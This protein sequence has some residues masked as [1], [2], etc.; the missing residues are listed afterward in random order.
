MPAHPHSHPRS[1]CQAHPR[2]Q[3]LGGW[4][5]GWQR[6]RRPLTGQKPCLWFPPPRRLFLPGAG[7]GH[8]DDGREGPQVPQGPRSP[9][10]TCPS[11]PRAHGRFPGRSGE[12]VSS[13]SGEGIP[14]APPPPLAHGSPLR[15]ASQLEEGGCGGGDG[16][17]GGGQGGGGDG[18][19]GCGGAQCYSPLRQLPRAQGQ[20]RGGRGSH[21]WCDWGLQ[22]PKRQIPRTCQLPRK[23]RPS[24]PEE[25]SRP[26]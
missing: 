20:Q 15:C 19:G 10:G 16:G 4:G 11:Q 24:L 13:E 12:G 14:R 2:Q 21:R 8:V 7:R 5:P 25:D 26:E 17:G 18:G 9:S 6:R 1:Q 3:R 23:L 22:A